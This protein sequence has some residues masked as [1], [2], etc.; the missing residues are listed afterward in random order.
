MKDINDYSHKPAQLET[1]EDLYRF[2]EGIPDEFWC[3]DMLEIHPYSGEAIQRCAMGHVNAAYS[4]NAFTDVGHGI[5]N[6]LFPTYEGPK[7]TR[8]ADLVVA[9]NNG[10]PV[11]GTWLCRE[12]DV[13]LDG[14]SVKSRVLK[15]IR[16]I[17]GFHEKAL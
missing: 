17:Q 14:A 16:D 8:A 1:Q 6:R 11:D 9:S 7:Y 10:M 15:S 2:F 3:V 13:E 4:E 5:V 12:R